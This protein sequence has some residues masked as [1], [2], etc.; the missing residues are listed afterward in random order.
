MRSRPQAVSA[1]AVLLA[2]FSVLNLLLP[3]F[4]IEG[5]PAIAPYL[6]VGE[7]AAGLLGAIGLWMLRKWGIWLTVIVSVLNVVVDAAGGKVGAPNTALQV[8]ATITVVG[9][10]LIVVLVVLPSSRRAFR[11]RPSFR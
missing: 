1:A 4:P 5:I 7:G 2:L 3:L 9:F 6:A 8:A 11:S 10:V